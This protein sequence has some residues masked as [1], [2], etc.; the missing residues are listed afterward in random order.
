MN[1][2]ELTSDQLSFLNNTFFKNPKN[3]KFDEYN[4][5]YIISIT[6]KF[7]YKIYLST[8]DRRD[9]RDAYL[10]LDLDLNL[11]DLNE[12]F[13]DIKVNV[14]LLRLCRQLVSSYLDEIEDVLNTENTINP[15]YDIVN[16]DGQLY[17]I[18][19]TRAGKYSNS[20][21]IIEN[22]FILDQN[23]KSFIAKSI[24]TVSKNIHLHDSII[25][26]ELRGE[27]SGNIDIYNSTFKYLNVDRSDS[28]E[29]RNCN[30]YKLDIVNSKNIF[31]DTSCKDNN[32]DIINSDNVRLNNCEFTHNVTISGNN[33]FLKG[34]FDVPVDTEIIANISPDTFTN[35]IFKNYTELETSIFYYMNYSIKH[36]PSDY[37]IV[38]LADIP[39]FEKRYEDNRSFKYRTSNITI[40]KFF[41]CYIAA[42]NK[43]RSNEQRKIIEAIKEEF[44]PHYR[45]S[46]VQSYLDNVVYE[47]YNS[48][49]R[50]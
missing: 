45:N 30:K 13:L 3:V 43:N 2:K 12:S 21:L 20:E 18:Y 11:I 31:I 50:T 25:E 4:V 26:Y 6:S 8:N 48:N 42:T 46:E 15:K 10:E 47:F 27:P 5:K 38:Y 1:V 19:T 40:R 23:D 33:I 32:L 7:N 24:N 14:E 9:I 37:N 16:K 22:G 35:N 39:D 28:V 49:R 36:I 41:N 34:K 44:A 29:I 17:L